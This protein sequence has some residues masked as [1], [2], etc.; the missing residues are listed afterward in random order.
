[1]YR[2]TNPAL[3][4][5]IFTF[6]TSSPDT[7]ETNL[8]EGIISKYFPQT[9]SSAIFYGVH[10]CSWIIVALSLCL[11]LSPRR[12]AE[13]SLCTGVVGN[14]SFC[15]RHHQ[16][17]SHTVS[18]V[19]RI[20]LPFPR[21]LF[22]INTARVG[23]K[24]NE[25]RWSPKELDIPV[26]PPASSPPTA[27]RSLALHAWRTSRINWLLADR[28]SSDT[29]TLLLS[30]IVPLAIRYSPDNPIILYH[31]TPNGEL[32]EDIISP[33]SGDSMNFMIK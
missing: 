18:L 13:I 5:N 25:S 22:E 6:T 17:L 24:E 9:P 20:I 8:P 23:G 31:C 29:V 28:Y 3:R 32:Q 11:S 14:Y 1:M 26:V 19:C 27:A 15:T 16:R 33:T 10:T 7:R 30:N 12:V 21:L 2:R 4:T